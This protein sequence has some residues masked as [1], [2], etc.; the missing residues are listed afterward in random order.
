MKAEIN[1]IACQNTR[2]AGIG[3]EMAL[4]DFRDA[5]TAEHKCNESERHRWVLYGE[6]STHSTTLEV[7]SP[8]LVPVLVHGLFIRHLRLVT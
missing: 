8:V 2:Q 5:S 6:P 3:G 7:R 1:P 4:C